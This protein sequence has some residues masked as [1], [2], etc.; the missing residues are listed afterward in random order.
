MTKSA[1]FVEYFLQRRFFYEAFAMAQ[2]GKCF[3]LSD[4]FVVCSDRVQWE[5]RKGQKAER[6]AA[7]HSAPV[8]R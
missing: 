8:A 1:S 4:F 3:I 7:D 5:Q 6:D 2:M